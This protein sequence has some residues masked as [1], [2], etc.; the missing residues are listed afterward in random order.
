MNMTVL[1]SLSFRIL[2]TIVFGFALQ[3]CALDEP[4][5]DP[6]GPRYSG[7]FRT[8]DETPSSELK[9]IAYNLE[10]AEGV[11]RAIAILQEHPLDNADV[12]LMQEMDAPATERIA[13]ALDFAYVYYPATVKR[14][15]DFGNAVLSR[16]EILEDSKVILPH[17]DPYTG[18][19]RIAV[20]AKLRLESENGSKESLHVYSVHTATM[21]LGLR[22]R[23][24]QA[25]AIVRNTNET[26]GAAFIGGDFNTADP[27]STSQTKKIMSENNF[28]LMS[29]EAKNTGSGYG[30]KLT[31]DYIFG[32]GAREIESGTFVG[33]AGS[34]HQPIWVQ[35]SID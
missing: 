6:S 32:R 30:Q 31:L 8:T 13:E 9:I 19:R 18:S 26:E 15:Q 21:A 35:C 24:E 20:Q 14:G 10:F 28:V 25:E 5:L 7:D 17:A 3:N 12:I 11:E 22:A 2:T 33:D 27:G 23:L 1:F 4:Y 34:D 29:S 16:Y